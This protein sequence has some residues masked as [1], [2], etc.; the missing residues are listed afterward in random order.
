MSV[1]VSLSNWIHVA[2]DSEW[3]PSAAPFS[4]EQFLEKDQAI[5]SQHTERLRTSGLILTGV[6][7]GTAAPTLALEFTAVN[8]PRKHQGPESF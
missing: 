6:L 7:D 1:P 3:T 8:K 2:W 4:R 5:S